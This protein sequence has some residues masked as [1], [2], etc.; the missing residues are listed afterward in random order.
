VNLVTRIDQSLP[1]ESD[2]DRYPADH[3]FIVIGENYNTHICSP[4][5][6]PLV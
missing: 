2:R 6:Y 1:E 3:G 5:I 4:A